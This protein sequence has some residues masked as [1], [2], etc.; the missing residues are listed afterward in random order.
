MSN[1]APSQ[2]ITV[3]MV[4]RARIAWR[5]I[6]EASEGTVD[7]SV[8]MRAALVA[9]FVAPIQPTETTDEYNMANW[10]VE[11]GDG[12]GVL[13]ID[14]TTPSQHSELADKLDKLHSDR[15]VDGLWCNVMPKDM[16]AIISA[17]RQAPDTAR[18]EALEEA[19]K[20]AFKFAVDVNA[21]LTPLKSEWQQAG[22]WTEYD[23]MVFQSRPK[24]AMALEAA[25]AALANKGNYK[26]DF[27]FVIG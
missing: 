17:L 16:L 14:P 21:L 13:A 25:L 19:A 7:M 8:L 23:E 2:P 9:A 18:V 3:E 12:A 27:R 26:V 24:V 15:A 4:N 22:F 1:P 11:F 5:D 6:V 10:D 20:S